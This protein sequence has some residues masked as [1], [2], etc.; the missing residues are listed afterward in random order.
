MT[1][2][3]TLEL[4]L[5]QL[6]RYF[7]EQSPNNSVLFSYY[8]RASVDRC[9]WSV[10]GMPKLVQ[11]ITRTLTGMPVIDSVIGLKIASVL[12][13]WLKDSVALALSDWLRDSVDG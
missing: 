9:H 5:L 3:K 2:T 1:M 4:D 6:Q 7:L 10:S 8:V 12:S 13:D 11:P